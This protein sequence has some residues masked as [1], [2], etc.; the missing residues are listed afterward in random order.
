MIS[1]I[2]LIV[3]IIQNSF[4]MVKAQQ[5]LSDAQTKVKQLQKQKQELFFGQNKTQSSDFLEKQIRDKLK[6]VKPGEA[7]VV[8]PSTLQNKSEEKLYKYHASEEMA[9][10]ITPTWRLWWQLFF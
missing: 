2:L 9:Q 7:L 4:D 1:I 5:R 3:S 10:I 8:L 6:L